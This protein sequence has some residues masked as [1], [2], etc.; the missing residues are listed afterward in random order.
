MARS[1]CMR[2]EERQV[3]VLACARVMTRRLLPLASLA[4]AT[5]CASVPPPPPPVVA[6]P[7]EPKIASILRLE[8]HRVLED[9][10]SRPA[11]PPPPVIDR[12]GRPLPAPPPPP[13][14]DLVSLLGDTDARVRRR[15]ALAIGRVGLP[16]GVAPLTGQLQDPDAEV[17]AMVAFALGLIGD[18]AAVDP[19]VTA[20]GDPNVLVKGRAAHGL[21]LLGPEKAARAAAPIA[22]MVRQLVEAGA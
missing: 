4:V 13:R 12:K 7:Y 5:A 20:L 17:R 1:I 16:A 21:G 6:P 19:L 14:M 15:A 22:E 9:A 18:A 11:P 3:R 10:R 8:D 2:F